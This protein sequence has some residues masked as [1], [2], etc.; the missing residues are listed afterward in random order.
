MP[1]PEATPAEWRCCRWLMSAAFSGTSYRVAERERERDIVAQSEGVKRKTA[2]IFK[3]LE[4]SRS[5]AIHTFRP[6]ELVHAR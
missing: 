2:I 5:S 1:D 3:Y 4:K 6:Y